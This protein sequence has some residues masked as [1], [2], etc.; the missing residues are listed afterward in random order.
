MFPDFLC[1]AVYLTLVVHVTAHYEL[2]SGCALEL[3][4]SIPEGLTY[5]FNA[6]S[7][8]S[9]YDAWKSLLNSAYKQLNIASFYWTLLA[10]PRFN[11]SAVN[12]GKEI[13]NTLLNL[14]EKIQVNIAQSGP[15]KK[16]SELD[17]MIAAGKDI[18]HG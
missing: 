11:F 4:E 10:E 9:T 3:V 7:H 13:F 16:D 6:P 17:T 2:D 1:I 12:Q 15:E 8:V 14:S 5:L 18:I